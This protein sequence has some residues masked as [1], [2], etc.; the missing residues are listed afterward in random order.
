M[1]R[2]RR[3]LEFEVGDKVFLKISPTRE[4]IRFD[5]RG[6]LS[7]KFIE[8]FK[9]FERVGEVAYRLALTASLDGVHDVFHVSQL[10]RLSEMTLM[11]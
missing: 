6:K 3:P 1:G 2:L 10:R 11:L 4:I 8:P 5:N 7:P 9:I